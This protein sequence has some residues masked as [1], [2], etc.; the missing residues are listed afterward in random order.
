MQDAI[1]D[2]VEGE[3]AVEDELVVEAKGSAAACLASKA[4][5]WVAGKAEEWVL[6]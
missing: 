4:E 3:W 5:E 2:P 1:P 6:S